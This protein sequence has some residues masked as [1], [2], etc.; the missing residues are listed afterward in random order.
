MFFLKSYKDITYLFQI[1]LTLIKHTLK[2]NFSRMSLDSLQ[3]QHYVK[4]REHLLTQC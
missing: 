3:T 1:I 2:R 4:K